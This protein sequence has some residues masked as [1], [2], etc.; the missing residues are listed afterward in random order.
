MPVVGAGRRELTQHFARFC[1]N[2]DPRPRERRSE[3]SLADGSVP[4]ADVLLDLDDALLRQLETSVT[5]PDG[6]HDV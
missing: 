2:V 1:R 5:A 6:G 3:L 4:M